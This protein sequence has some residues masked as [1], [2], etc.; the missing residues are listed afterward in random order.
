MLK[1]MSVQIPLAFSLNFLDITPS[2]SMLALI[3]ALLKIIV[4]IVL[5]F[6]SLIPVIK[7]LCEGPPEIAKLVRD[8]DEDASLAGYLLEQL[9]HGK[10]DELAQAFGLIDENVVV[11]VEDAI[12]SL[13]HCFAEYRRERR[14]ATQSWLDTKETTGG[15][16]D[17]ASDAQ[18]LDKIIAPVDAL[19]LKATDAATQV[20]APSNH[21]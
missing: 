12:N 19:K 3:L 10:Y 7:M 1:R 2:W 4:M 20:R 17:V 6:K 16:F 13:E 11:I 21:T 9:G 18:Q 15:L 14:D 5:E 8:K